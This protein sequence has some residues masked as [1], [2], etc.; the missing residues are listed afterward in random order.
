MLNMKG[1]KKRSSYDSS[2]DSQMFLYM[3]TLSRS[4]REDGMDERC[5]RTM[6]D[7]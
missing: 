5:R 2:Q 7:A 4:K 6:H 3:S 1:M